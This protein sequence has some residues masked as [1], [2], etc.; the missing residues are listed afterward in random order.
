MHH[1]AVGAR[2]HSAFTY[3]DS[4][5]NVPDDFPLDPGL[6]L[7]WGP[8]VR[9]RAIVGSIFHAVIADTELDGWAKRLILR[10]QA[11]R[12]QEIRRI[13]QSPPTSSLNA[14][15]FLLAVDDFSRV[16]GLRFKDEHGTFSAWRK[17]GADLE[18]LRGRGTFRR[19]LRLK[20]SILDADGNFAIGKFS[21]VNDERAVTKGE[22]LAL[23]LA[24]V[25][26]IDAA[27][28]RLTCEDSLQYLYR[29]Q[30]MRQPWGFSQGS[31]EQEKA[32]GP[33]LINRSTIAEV[34]LTGLSLTS[35]PVGIAENS[36]AH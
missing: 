24:C 32:L 29:L 20:C 13:G 35:R 31:A 14:V 36:G 30:K 3:H 34:P 21:S 15:D 2:E 18:Y 22:L 17:Q 11:K 5:L 4:W 7:V 27:A 25:A 28:A 33:W 26:G 8:Q 19:G 6:P 23:R 10:D 16:V 12:R 9:G 1:D